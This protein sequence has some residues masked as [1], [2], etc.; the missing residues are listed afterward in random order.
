MFHGS[1]NP[2]HKSSCWISAP[3]S[4]V[5]SFFTQVDMFRDSLAPVAAG[6]PKTVRDVFIQIN[7]KIEFGKTMV[8][9][10]RL[11]WLNPSL[12]FYCGKNIDVTGTI[13][14]SLPFLVCTPCQNLKMAFLCFYLWMRESGI[15]NTLGLLIC[16]VSDN[17]LVESSY[18]IHTTHFTSSLLRRAANAE[19]DSYGRW[20]SHKSCGIK[21]FQIE[22]NF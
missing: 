11:P 3:S 2:T 10:Q 14:F 12:P 18:I 8:S 15:T 20:R 13:D 9:F 16:P 5:F 22:V 19:D 7:T 4:W 17:N 1:L 6:T 21:M